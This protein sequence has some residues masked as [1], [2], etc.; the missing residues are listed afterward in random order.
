MAESIELATILVTDLV[1]STRLA[2]SVGPVRADELRDEHFDVLRE[3]IRAWGGQEFRSTG[4]GMMVAF[5]SASAA[6][7]CAVS[8]QQLIERR[9]RRAEP[10]LQVRIGL[11]AGESTVQNGEYFGMPSIE[12]ARLCDK[13][14]GGGDPGVAGGANAGRP[15]RGD[16]FRLR[17]RA[18][19]QRVPR[20]GRGIR[21]P[22]DEAR[23]RDR[24][25]RRLAAAGAAPVGAAGRLR[26]SR[27]RALARWSARGAPCVR[28]R[29]RWC[30]SPAS[31]GSARA[32]SP[33]LAAHG[34]HGE[35]F[36]VLWG[37]CSEELAVPYEP[38]IA[39]CS[40]LVEHAPARA[41]RAARRA[42]RRRAC[43]PG[44]RPAAP[45]ARSAG[46]GELGSRDRALP[47]LLGRVRRARGARDVGARLPRARRPALG[48]HA[49]GRA[50]EAPDVVRSVVCAPG[51]RRLP[52]LG[53]RQGSSA[54]APCSR[55]C[56]ASTASSASRSRASERSRCRR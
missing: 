2:T 38:W 12:A 53:P 10:K 13:A 5:R 41:P 42:A 11:G 22:V 52:R 3:A 32:A 40:Q 15:A 34:A 8:M 6:V 31:P 4:D 35:G 33:S 44:A 47:A 17:R 48:G 56:G 54:R 27:R 43:A 7:Q 46:A 20:T 24:R 14:A 26:R 1:G 55:I 51:D 30:W 9:Y 37:A 16:P 50:V 39:V 28:A 19:V 49:V 36:A 21:R 23:G 29:S 18:R 25:C 45:V